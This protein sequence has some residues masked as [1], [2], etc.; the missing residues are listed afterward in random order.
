MTFLVAGA[1]VARSRTARRALLWILLALGAVVLSLASVFG[2]VLDQLD[3]PNPT[4]GCIA[5]VAAPPAPG[6]S[7]P[8]Q[9][10]TAEQQSNAA[11]I[12]ATGREMSVPDKGLWIALAVALQESG[13]RNLTYGDRDSLGLFQ[14]RPSAGWGTPEQVR[15]PR[16]AA[17]KFFQHLLAVPGWEAMPLT[18]AAQTVQRSAFPEAY[19]RWEQKAA[20]IL[21]AAGG[22]PATCA[23]NPAAA[24]AS[25]QAQ[26]ALTTAR[27]QL[28]KPYV[29]GA[30]GPNSFDCSGL[31][32]T[33]WKAAGVQLPR[34][35]AAQASAGQHV[36]LDQ[37]QPG[38][39]LFWGYGQQ[40]SGVYH[41]AMSLGGDQII[42]ASQPGVPVR[43]RAV[44]LPTGGAPGERELLP[45]A[46]RPGATAPTTA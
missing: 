2:I 37:L 43:T 44:R 10:V 24:A 8:G 11:A 41:V 39:L 31:T 29:W 42:E 4:G 6:T 46:I 32:M 1:Y 36:P 19:A 22:S 27:A 35:S 30:T 28:G 21:A 38:D 12:V 25:E 45:Y 33:A 40:A 9:A 3:S 15:D 34:T 20:D 23:T 7:A 26:T 13:L 16:Y 18:V 17:T 14:Q 5:G